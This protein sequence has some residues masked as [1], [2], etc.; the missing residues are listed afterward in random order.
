V[1]KGANRLTVKLKKNTITASAGKLRVKFNKLPKKTFAFWKKITPKRTG[2]AKRKTTLKNNTIMARYP[3]AER[4]DEGHSPQ[5]PKGMY[6]P[7]LEF[8]KKETK[9]I[10][11]K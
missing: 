3:Y 10:M 4:L 11:R 7:T 9:R 5:A 2:N 6:E 1:L 8:F